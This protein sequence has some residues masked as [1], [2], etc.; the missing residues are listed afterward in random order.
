MKTLALAGTLAGSL[1]LLAACSAQEPAEQETD[2]APLVEEA[3]PSA[4]AGSYE[5]T[6]EDGRALSRFLAAD[7][8]YIDSVGGDIIAQGSWQEEGDRLCLSAGTAEGETC[9]TLTKPAADGTLTITSE[10]GQT[11]TAEKTA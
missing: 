1:S 2:N 8:T 6:L 4:M 7:G 9:Y 3:P 11:L 10:N 5:I